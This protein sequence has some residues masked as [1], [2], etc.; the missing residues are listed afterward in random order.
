MLQS[1]NGWVGRP[2]R[3]LVRLFG[4]CAVIMA[5]SLVSG[6][7]RADLKVEVEV[8]ADGSD[9]YG[10][11]VFTFDDAVPGH[12]VRASTGVVVLS[13]DR[14][15]ALEA[16]EIPD[17]LPDYVTA[18]R[19]DPDGHALRLALT[20]P[21]AVNTMEAGHMLF[22]DLLPS[23]WTGHPPGLPQ[24]VV[25]ELA[26]L[27]KQVKR[28]EAAEER[29][30]R[31]ENARDVELR[32]ASLP[33]LTRFAF[34][35][36][37]PV[38]ARIERD[39]DVVRLRFEAF[40]RLDTAGLLSRLPDY[41]MSIEA[42]DGMDGLE[43][44]LT[45]DPDSA[46]RGFQEEAS[47]VVDV[48]SPQRDNAH[49]L[50]GLPDMSQAARR[51]SELAGAA[52]ATEVETGKPSATN[53]RMEAEIGPLPASLASGLPTEAE[54]KGGGAESSAQ[55]AD[56]SA[57]LS[58]VAPAQ[59]D[60][61]VR[62]EARRFG[63][64][65]RLIFPFAEST[66]AA[67]FKQADALWL[68]FDS[69]RPLDV[70]GV[71]DELTDIVAAVE[72]SRGSAHSVVRLQLDEPRLGSLT[73][74]DAFWVVTIGD[75]VMERPTPLN[76]SRV[77]GEGREPS[78]T[79]ALP[80]AARVHDLT[81]PESGQ[82]LSVVTAHAPAHGLGKA[83]NLVDFSA[84][85]SIHG[86][87]VHRLSDDLEVRLEDELVRIHRAGGLTM[88]LAVPDGYSTRS[89]AAQAAARPG[90]VDTGVDGVL[91]PGA[92]HGLISRYLRAVAETDDNDRTRARLR[93]AEAL[94]ATDLGAEALGQLRLV[95]EEDPA[96]MRRPEVRAMHGIALTLMHRYRAA[97][98]QFGR[99]DLDTS[100]D[101]ALW[102]GLAETRLG[103]WR[104]ARAAFA[105]GASA[106]S[107][108]SP[109]RQRLFGLASV[110]AALETGETSA[111]AVQLAQLREVTAADD[112]EYALLDGRLA[113]T[114]G[115]HRDAASAYTVAERQ[116]DSQ[117]AVEA[118]RRRI[119]IGL[120]LG[121]LD[122]E[123]AIEELETLAMVWRG[124]DTELRTLRELAG[125]HIEAGNHRR[126]F[127]HKK[128]ATIVDPGL[129]VTRALQDDMNQAFEALFLEGGADD[130]P[131]IE[132][133]A[134]YYD[135]RELTPIGHRGDE[136]IRW[137]AGR[138]IEVDLL[139][140]AAEL[141]AHQVDNRLSGAARS[142]VA[143]RLAKV[144]LMNGHPERALA[145]IA[146]TRQAVLPQEIQRSRA[147]L[148]ARAFAE[149]G[150]HDA[151]LDLLDA[152][153]EARD[154]KRL[155]AD[156][157]WRAERW[158]A[159]GEAYELLLGDQWRAGATLDNVALGDVLRSA[160]AFALAEDELGLDRLRR[161]FADQ[162]V[163]SDRAGAFAAITDAP[164]H[165]VE[166]FRALVAEIASLD[167]LDA[168]LDEYR[169]RYDHAGAAAA[170]RS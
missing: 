79:V 76:L 53:G 146:R 104:R 57:A 44:E 35:W 33:T 8:E 114:L 42:S 164:S 111:A 87:A 120:R 11:L 59:A 26:R 28:E 4:L 47:Y 121:E 150:R 74:D 55:A 20:Q 144:H 18:A 86:L 147:I 72:V 155:R 159:A 10:R 138:L 29:R 49:D 68:V 125:L 88:T 140:Q 160:I 6:P 65:A 100:T 61:P 73:V 2:S 1:R 98:E 7:A 50:S 41:V 80:G 13:F 105:Q 117:A 43:V 45:V 134:L 12:T 135:Y 149:T 67:V 128:A 85:P 99:D 161:K 115:N 136:V 60:G 19:R 90:F 167:T 36:E 39:L 48:S 22:V 82:R 14:S 75:A 139:D 129:A 126:A 108:Y 78:V 142:Q 133:L 119:L 52:P 5:L 9:G 37:E 54:D 17:Q 131:P 30:R 83:H 34:E 23:G 132:A 56:W 70:R 95:A 97:L 16:R 58:D 31:L 66:P 91:D 96:Y 63:E 15:V 123:E 93:L 169:A 151:A 103:R 127:E 69:A 156:A 157:L 27:A 113:E 106:L 168:F 84:R 165:E 71:E 143:A 110:R 122:T 166:E 107:S 112:P 77:V 64:S 25:A 51:I 89:A 148:E 32:I 124:D 62:V 118:R 137:L 3:T 46:V 109:E 40:G 170:G 158:Q 153:D 141:L 21:A 152:L 102:R 94:L 163:Q 145:V 92:V 24:E 81:C 154:V 101:V 38:A 162:M 116:A 130:M